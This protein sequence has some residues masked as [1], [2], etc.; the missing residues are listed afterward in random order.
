LAAVEFAGGSV[1]SPGFERSL[2]HAQPGERETLMRSA[3]ANLAWC[4]LTHRGYGA[5]KFTRMGL[6]A[7][8]LAFADVR[9]P[10]AAPPSVTRITAA[11]GASFGPGAWTL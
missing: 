2:S 9:T 8:W 6:E 11:A 10:L 5:L 7:E 1:S 3:N 4:D